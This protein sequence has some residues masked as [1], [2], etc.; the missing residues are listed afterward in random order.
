MELHLAGC[1]GAIACP[2]ALTGARR[3]VGTCTFLTG[4]PLLAPR[5]A[6]GVA[7]AHNRHLLTGFGSDFL[8]SEGTVADAIGSVSTDRTALE[9]GTAGTRFP[10]E[11]TLPLRILPVCALCW[12][13][14]CGG[15]C[16][17]CLT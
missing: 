5:P 16:T 10:M 14:W 2:R 17:S 15:Q 6:L 13:G 7:G 11:P 9:A 3:S 8:T 1:M 12:D 4:A